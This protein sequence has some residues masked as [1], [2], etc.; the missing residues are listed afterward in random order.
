MTN[1]LVLVFGVLQTTIGN[2]A[3]TLSAY[4]TKLDSVVQHAAS[5]YM[6]DSSRVGLSI[7]IIDHHRK[8]IYH[9]GET[10][11]G[12]KTHPDNS[13]LFEIG[14]LTKT[15]TGLL[16]AQ[17]IVEGKIRLND[18]VRHYLPGSYPNLQYLG[19]EPIKVGYLLTH[20]AQLPNASF[21]V[22]SNAASANEAFLLALH[23]VSLDSV[24]PFR[25]AYSNL[26]YQLLGVMLEQIYGVPYEQLL[27][28]RIAGPL[29]MKL[30]ST[31]TTNAN[32]KDVLLGYNAQRRPMPPQPVELAS[33]AG[34]RT[35]VVDMLEYLAYQLDEKDAAVRLTHRVVHGNIDESAEGFSWAVGKT[36]NWD[37]Y[38]R[39][40]GGTSGFRS[41]CV[42]YPDYQFGVILLSNQTDDNAGKQLYALASAIFAGIRK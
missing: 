19:G 28:T 11:P 27:R 18:D 22:P 16:V 24:R 14:S 30:T 38:W 34:I 33:A 8:S 6:A 21:V 40:D 41:F 17:A 10:A 20:T 25:Y 37:Y 5:I 12:S 36:W 13:K 39:A 15:F 29:G 32:R 7:G 9:L 23:R 4:Q 2:Q 1:A 26:G 31:T 3:P 35:T 42:M